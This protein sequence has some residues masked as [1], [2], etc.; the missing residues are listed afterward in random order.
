MKNNIPSNQDSK[1]NLEH[2]AASRH[3]YT[4]GKRIAAIQTWIAIGFPLVAA[5]IVTVFTSQEAKVWV[6]FFSISAAVVE[7]VLLDP[8]QKSR[9]LNGAVEQEMFDCAVLELDWPAGL[10]GPQPSIEST[11][12]ASGEI[13]KSGS[14]SHFKGWYHSEVEQ[15]P[16]HLGRIVCQRGNSWWDA[17]QRSQYA[18]ILRGL[19][20]VVVLFVVVFSLTRKRPLE[21]LVSTIY[22]PLSPL[23]IWGLKEHERHTSASKLSARLR[24]QA[25]NVWNDALKGAVQPDESARRSRD[26]QNG[27][28]HKRSTAPFLPNW[29]KRRQDRN[30]QDK[31]GKLIDRLLDEAR[32]ARAIAAGQ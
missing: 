27:I 22:A 12:S 2:F 15:L 9:R 21:D 30:Y 20:I 17:E 4:R 31:M 1:E 8:M 29:L 7:A 32:A 24:T 16:I 13:T 18:R 10:A 5:I 25:E 6:T 3:W 23:V 28:F 11:T 19:S 14:V 26:I